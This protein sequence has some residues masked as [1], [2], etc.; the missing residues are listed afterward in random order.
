M[1]AN[2]IEVRW[3]RWK[4]S[5]KVSKQALMTW[6]LSWPKSTYSSMT[7]N[8][9]WGI[10]PSPLRTLQENGKIN[11]LEG[12]KLPSHLH[13]ASLCRKT[14]LSLDDRS[15]HE[16]CERILTVP[17]MRERPMLRQHEIDQ[18]RIGQRR[19][20]HLHSGKTLYKPCLRVR[21]ILWSTRTVDPLLCP[22]KNE[23]RGIATTSPTDESEHLS[24]GNAGGLQN[25]AIA[26]PSRVRIVRAT[27]VLC[28][29]LTHLKIT[30]RPST[31]N[32]SRPLGDLRHHGINVV[33]RFCLIEP[34]NQILPPGNR[35]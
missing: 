30:M 1:H 31:T 28:N 19:Y 3:S 12:L 9:T 14:L 6:P 2:D 24:P 25:S 4:F 23:N 22:R 34:F 16:N 8:F 10:Y 35:L 7:L 33:R 26:I 27:P 15:C 18:L 32:L 29:N 17:D 11:I 21:I 20:P 13:V 5:A